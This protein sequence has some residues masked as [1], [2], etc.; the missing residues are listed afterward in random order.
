MPYQKKHCVPRAYE[1][2]EYLHSNDARTIRVLAEY[3]EPAYRFKKE[4]IN[5]TVVFFGSARSLPLEKARPLSRKMT[6]R[7]RTL[8]GAKKQDLM[9]R[10]QRIMAFSYYYEDA[11]KLAR[12]ITAWSRKIKDPARR[13][14]LCSGGGP[15]MMEAA[16]RGASQAGGKSI[17]LNISLPFEQTPNPYITPRL[18][19]QF[20]Y[21][22]IRKFWFTY[23]AK[24]IVVFPGGFGTMDEAFEI[25]TLC[26]T[27]KLEKRLPI[28]FYGKKYWDEILHLDGLRRWGAIDAAD[29]K[30]IKTVDSPEEAYAYLI[31]RLAGSHRSGHP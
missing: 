10:A 24:A 21:F 16:N 17:G 31:P 26:Q 20:H 1:N 6:A 4:K 13:F 3:M 5:N 28:L 27:K 2:M 19:F 22:F 25:L 18:N 15:G 9:E 23:L 12:M 8:A 30:L 29:L 7:A 14:Y 11:V